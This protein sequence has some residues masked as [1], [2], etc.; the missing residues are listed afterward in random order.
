MADILASGCDWARA[1]IYWLPRAAPWPGRP[2]ALL[3]RPKHEQMDLRRQANPNRR[4][5]SQSHGH[6]KQSHR[7]DKMRRSGVLITSSS[8]LEGVSI[9]MVPWLQIM[10][11]AQHMVPTPRRTPACLI[12]SHLNINMLCS[13]MDSNTVPA[14]RFMLCALSSSRFARALPPAPAALARPPRSVARLSKHDGPIH[15]V[16]AAET[17]TV[18]HMARGRGIRRRQPRLRVLS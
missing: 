10:S 15:A 2:H 3:L 14:T 12:W 18:L 9:P 17:L 5:A 8:R 11:L 4:D 7:Q 1:E 16:V 6:A 13:H